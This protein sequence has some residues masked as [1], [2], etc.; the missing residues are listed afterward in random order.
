LTDPI[1]FREIADG[2]L[3]AFNGDRTTWQGGYV[4][5]R[6]AIWDSLELAGSLSANDPIDDPNHYVP[7]KNG[8]GTV[9]YRHTYFHGDLRMIG[10][11]EGVYWGERILSRYLRT[12]TVPEASVINFRISATIKDFTIFWGWNNVYPERYQLLGGFPMIH[13]EEIYGVRWNFLD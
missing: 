6:W 9:T 10:R 5:G 3:Q 8:W 7:D 4:T 11:V 1:V 12:Y 13:R 2:F